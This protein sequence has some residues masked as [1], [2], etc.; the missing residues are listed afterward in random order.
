M[1]SFHIFSHTLAIFRHTLAI[2]LVAGYSLYVKADVCHYRPGHSPET[3]SI[4]LPSTFS[5][6]KDTPSG[7]QLF[8]S[9]IYNHK[10]NNIYYCSQIHPWGIRN[11]R[12]TDSAT[13]DLYPIGNTG[14]SWQYILNGQP[15]KGYGSYTR[16]IASY[17]FTDSSTAIRLIKTGNIESGA[18]IPAG[19]LGGIQAGGLKTSTITLNKNSTITALSCQS[20]DIKVNMGEYDAGEF[21]EAGSTSKP[22]Y[23]SIGLFN[24]PSGINKVD[25]ILQPT[26]SSPV[27]R[28]D[29]G[30]I[31]LNEKSTAKGLALQIMDEKG[32]PITI[33][34]NYTFN[35][36]GNAGGNFSI[37]LSARYY[38]TS[39]SS[40]GSPHAPGI[41]AGTADAEI[42]FSMS[43][44]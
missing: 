21:R 43:Y 25:Y 22:I 30:I 33:N 14:I 4:D 11:N 5:V 28:T 16:G 20:P 32:T 40:N 6:P 24:C 27:W 31:N 9:R 19:E 15:Q 8:E 36:Y 3:I 37:P 29:L 41:V 7:T 23:F 1:I 39:P 38:R 18:S 44:L 2:F 13:S 26:P 10:S 35:G 17:Y 12:G 42:I 34:K